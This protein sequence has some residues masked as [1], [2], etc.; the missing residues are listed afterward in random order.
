MRRRCTL[1]R[2]AQAPQAAP[3]VPHEAFD[4]EDERHARAFPVQQPFGHDAASQTHCPLVV[5][6][7]CP[8]VQAAHV[9]PPAPHE[10]L[11]CAE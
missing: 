4:C 5:L 1:A 6:H 3:P 11:D 10:G 8:A 9:A 2:V 7:S